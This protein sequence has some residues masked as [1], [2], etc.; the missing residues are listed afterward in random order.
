LPE[1]TLLYILPSR[2]CL[3][4]VLGNEAWSRFGG[5]APG[6]GGCRRLPARARPLTFQYGSTT[7]FSTART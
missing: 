1:H 7:A 4:D 3:P 6:T 5:L 2:Y